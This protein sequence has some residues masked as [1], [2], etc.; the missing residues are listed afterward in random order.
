MN[1]LKFMEECKNC[2]HFIKENAEQKVIIVHTICDIGICEKVKK[3][4]QE[5]Q[6]PVTPAPGTKIVRI[7][8]NKKR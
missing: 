8:W 4:W 2:P 7:N 3:M 6:N 1:T 5:E